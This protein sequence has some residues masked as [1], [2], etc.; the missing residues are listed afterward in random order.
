[1]TS[2]DFQ[3]INVKG[4]LDASVH[5]YYSVTYFKKCKCTASADL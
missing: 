5:D 4:Q 3:L 1:M 2:I